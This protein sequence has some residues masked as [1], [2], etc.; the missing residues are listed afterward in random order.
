MSKSFPARVPH[1][2]R[3]VLAMLPVAL[4]LVLAAAVPAVAAGAPKV[5][6]CGVLGECDVAEVGATS[7]VL[8]PR[9]DTNGY[10]T[11]Y[12]LEYAMVDSGPWTPAPGGSGSISA[13]EGEKTLHVELTGLSPETTYY[14]REFVSNAA[15]E[16]TSPP[17]SF[18]TVAPPVTSSP[19][20]ESETMSNITEHG[21]TLETQ[22]NPDGFETEYELWLECGVENFQCG[23]AERVG[24]GHLP[25]GDSGQAVSAVLSDLEHGDAYKYWVVATSSEGT[26]KGAVRIFA[27]SE[28]WPGPVSETEAASNVTEHGASLA[29]KIYPEGH[30]FGKF[31]YF[32][33][34]GA[35]MS[36]GASAPAAPGGTIGPFASCGPIC[37][38]E[39]TGPKKVSVD[40]TD[41][42]PGITY[43]YRLVSTNVKE[44]Y[45]SFGN[46]ATFTTD[47]EKAPPS[48]DS[49]TPST[50]VDGQPGT[51]STP[52]SLT[53]ASVTPLV[54][55][56][57]K[58]VNSKAL[59]KS[60]KLA[61]ALKRCEKELKRK[62]AT[63][64]WQAM[65]R[66]ATTARDK[67]KNASAQNRARRR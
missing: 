56:L 14:V 19:S 48:S 18:E 58:T 13:A 6:S 63:C 50:T 36:Y 21:V 15:G 60:Q 62:R 10:E 3:L 47:S 44:G 29:G 54:S 37:E 59:T 32:F 24:S 55:P 38:G 17:T 43:H 12:R 53:S 57:L 9:I 20:I 28:T 8:E 67:G 30:G 41:L 45:R 65:K 42:E 2:S 7:V 5:G 27:P 23:S 16:A 61:K 33:E 64:K 25:A 52:S 46:D 11:A 31:E 51:S 35:S 49:E 4:V 22:I 26:T 40:L 1:T 34:Y 66:Y 39:A